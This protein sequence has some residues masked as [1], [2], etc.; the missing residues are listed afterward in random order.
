MANLK[1]FDSDTNTWKTLVVGAQGPQGIQGIQGE[2]GSGPVNAI[3][4]GA[5]EI[6][7]RNFTSSTANSVYL[8]DRWVTRASDGT[9]TFT[10]EAFSPGAAPL[11]PYESAKFLKISSTGQ[12]ASSARSAVAQFI[13]D[14]RTF[15]GSTVTLSFFAK[16]DSGTPFISVYLRQDFG[17]GGSPSAGADVAG[18]KTTISTSWTRYSFTF[19]VPSISE[20]TIGTTTSGFL[21]AFLTTSAGSS[22]N[23]NTDSMGIQTAEISIWGIQLEAGSVATPFKRNANSIQG[24][25]AACQRYYYQ[26]TSSYPQ[27][28]GCSAFTTNGVV[29]SAKFPVTMRV[30]PAVAITGFRNFGTGTTA[31]VTGLN[32]SITPDGMGAFLGTFSSGSLTAG[33]AFTFGLSADAEL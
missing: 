12:T 24:E 27:P 25:L 14:V 3:I 19:S 20:K 29:G 9:T 10:S 28:F 2:T 26:S 6:N 1:Y 22:F 4:N 8:F 11:A 31:T 7:Q 15:A 18:Q 16:A 5:F 33:N 21:A 23:T 13:E 30:S 17:T 32:A